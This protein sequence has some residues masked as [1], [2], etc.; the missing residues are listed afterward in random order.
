[1]VI[2]EQ[3]H[4]INHGPDKIYKVITDTVNYHWRS[5]LSE[6]KVIDA[7][8]FI[9]YSKKNVPTFFEVIKKIKNKYY[10]V[11][12]NNNE[13]EG[14]AIITLRPVD[15]GTELIIK[16]ELEILDNKKR[17]LGKIYL[18]KRQN[19]YIANLKQHLECSEIC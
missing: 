13:I 3:T 5:D 12:I 1:M 7:N 14:T 10:E 17:I 9:E 2:L 4:I 11:S 16:E 18:K 19:K 8:H 15:D 6:I